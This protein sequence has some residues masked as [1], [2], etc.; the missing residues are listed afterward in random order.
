MK[1]GLWSLIVLVFAACAHGSHPSFFSEIDLRTLDRI[2]VQLGGRVVPLR[3]FADAFVNDVHGDLPLRTIDGDSV[4]AVLV[5][6]EAVL[7]P[8]RAMEWVTLRERSGTV[9]TAGDV[10]VGIL[11]EVSG[12]LSDSRKTHSLAELE[13]R[14]ALVIFAADEIHV[15]P[16]ANDSGRWIALADTDDDVLLE[17]LDRLAA[18][19]RAGDP[20]IANTSLRDLA[21]IISDAQR[22]VGVR[23]WLLALE[24]LLEL[25][26][27]LTVCVLLYAMACVLASC[28]LRRLA[29]LALV[30][31]IAGHLFVISA[32]AIVMHRIPLQNHYESMLAVGAMVV[33]VTLTMSSRRYQ[34][35]IF[36]IGSGLTALLIAAAE[37]L[38]MPGRLLELEAGILSSAAILKYHVLTILAGYALILLGAGIGATV[39]FKRLA[40]ATLEDISRLHRL[41]VNLGYFA[42]WV[43]GVGILLGAIWA[44]RAW[45]RWWAFDPKE[46]WALITWLFYLAMVHIPASRVQAHRQPTMV[47]VLHLLGLLAM[48]WT[49]F[50][51]NLLMNSLHAYT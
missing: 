31:G 6:L 30:V 16:A 26:P 5:L 45:G 43:L 25:L 22:D 49:Y 21:G 44:D 13:A 29:L 38:N 40:G 17:M 19:W 47:A 12:D 23:H 14:V 33:V 46:T 24:R 8:E 48:L 10:L 37:W 1:A 2:G 7:D 51:V 18:A 20:S 34:P 28:G 11:S 35:A 39:L 32:R 9:R 27:L 42:F 3:S 4:D 15:L 41:Q 50:G 36:M